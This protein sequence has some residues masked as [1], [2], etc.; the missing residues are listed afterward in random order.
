MAYFPDLT[1]YT[2]STRMP[3]EDRRPPL[4]NVGWL[5]HQHDYPKGTTPEAFR[6]RLMIFCENPPL[7][8]VSCGYHPCPFC[9]DQIKCSAEIRI[10]GKDVEYCAPSIVEHYIIDH[11][12]RPPDAFVDAVMSAPLP[13]SAEH[14]AKYG[15]PSPKPEP[16]RWWQFWKRARPA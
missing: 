8:W 5:D 13:G 9:G 4:L 10:P 7:L 3:T 11:G 6:E 12:Y 1:P 16:A 15:W 14:E 2:Y